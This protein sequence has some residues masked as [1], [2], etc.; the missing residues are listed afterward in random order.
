M[1]YLFMKRFLLG[2]FA[3]LGL[4]AACDDDITAGGQELTPVFVRQWGSPG[5]GDGQFNVYVV[6]WYNARIQK[7]TDNGTFL[8]LRTHALNGFDLRR[9]AT[10]GGSA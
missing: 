10:A 6:D 5:T 3:I 1:Y 2:P 8:G 4:L 7:F 9:R